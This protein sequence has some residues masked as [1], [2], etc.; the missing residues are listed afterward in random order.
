MGRKGGSKGTG[1]KK[2]GRTISTLKRN[3][4]RRQKLVKAGKLKPKSTPKR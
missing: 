3:N 2:G 4:L 1:K